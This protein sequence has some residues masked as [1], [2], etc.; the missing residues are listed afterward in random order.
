MTFFYVHL[1]LK[2]L[3][4]LGLKFTFKPIS[5]EGVKMK[6]SLEDGRLIEVKFGQ[7]DAY[8][9]SLK[10]IIKVFLDGYDL[11][12]SGFFP[13]DF[14]EDLNHETLFKQNQYTLLSHVNVSVK[15]SFDIAQKLLLHVDNL[16]ESRVIN[17]AVI[18]AHSSLQYVSILDK[19]QQ[20]VLAAIFY[21]FKLNGGYTA[22]IGT[23]P[24]LSLEELIFLENCLQHN[25]YLKQFG[26]IISVKDFI[27]PVRFAYQHILKKRMKFTSFMDLNSKALAYVYDDIPT[28]TSKHD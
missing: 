27:E 1:Y 10:N 9:I 13:L 15:D 6:L 14:D 3:H 18:S 2:A 12:W 11:S 23:R 8:T 25:P 24:F 7:F 26:H 16:L 17:P 21:K 4:L 19:K 20:A 28:S 22:V 5:D